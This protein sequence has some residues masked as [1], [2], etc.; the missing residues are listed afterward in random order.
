MFVV[1]G[2][3]HG[4]SCAPELVD[5]AAGA[6]EM[7]GYRVARN[8]PYAGGHISGRH[9]RPEKGVHALQLEIDRSGY[10]D[11]ALRAP[12]PGFSVACD[13]IAHIVFAIEGRLLRPD[14]AQAAE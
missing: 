9:G 13:L 10:L 8:I 4:A 5:A 1:L 14:L 3:R 6:A 11:E 12:G 2:D 7:L